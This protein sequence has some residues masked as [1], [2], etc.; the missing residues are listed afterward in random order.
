MAVVY[1]KKVL[2]IKNWLA[3]DT[4]RLPGGG[5]G[6]GETAES[7][8]IR[9]IKEELHIEL[10]KTKLQ[11]LCTDNNTVDGIRY[12]FKIFVYVTDVLPKI[13][14]DNYEIVEFGWFDEL[15]VGLSP[16]LH[17]TLELLKASRTAI[18]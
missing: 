17:Q 7:A 1:D 4:W 9:E 10:K 6:R 8:A 18:I 15:P 16:D 3:R 11:Y 13:L 2:L 14:P 5:I 12:P